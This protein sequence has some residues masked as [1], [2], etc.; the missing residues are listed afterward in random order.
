MKSGYYRI[1][2]A[3]TV[4]GGNKTGQTLTV[5]T[6]SLTISGQILIGSSGAA[7]AFVRAEKQGGGFSGTQ[8]DANG[9]YILPVDAGTWKIL[10]VAEGYAEAAYAS[11]PI[12]VST[13]VSGKNI[14]LTTT[15]SLD[16][17]KSKPITPS[18]GGTL[19][20]TTAGVKLTIPAN[21]LGSG[22]SAGNIQAKETN[23]VRKTSSATPIGDKAQEIKATDSDGNPI[24]TLND[25]INVEMSYSTA[26]LATTRSSG[27]SSINTKTEV[28]KLQMAYWDET[29]QNWVTLPT[30]ITYYKSDGT[31]LDGSDTAHTPL[32]NLSNVATTTMSAPTTHLSLYAPISSTGENPPSTPSGLTATAASVSQINLS[33]T[34]VSGATSYDIYQSTT[35]DGTYTRLGSEPTVSSGSTVS[36]SDTGLSAGTAYYYKI[37][38]LNANGESVAS[39]AVSATTN[40]APA[41]SPGSSGIPL[42]QLQNQQTQ[43]QQA[44]TTTEAIKEIITET[45]QTIKE[46]TETAKQ[47]AQEFAQ[48]IV[49]ITLEAA[50]VIKA[51]VDNILNLMGVKRNV[52]SEQAVINKYLRPLV[53][54]M[55]TVTADA[56]HALTNF[57]SYGTPTTKILG[58]GE[59]AGVINSY[60]SAFG[61]LPKTEAEW[62]DVIK[63]G[64]GRWPSEINKQSE[65]NAS[66]AFE[67]IYKRKADRKNP[68]D[69]AAITVIAYG[70]R[71]AK[72]NTDSEKAAIKS[73]KAIYGY[74]PKTAV[75]WDIVRAIAYSGAKR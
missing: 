71:P 49:D 4:N 73:F 15:V 33:W 16:P 69:D 24:N 70:L 48:K 39:S 10:A 35:S 31:I 59:R 32:D 6:A 27:D 25:S 58:A 42:N 28:D 14:T 46:V 72:R 60:K 18:S 17:I 12:T 34:V 53:A 29:T 40:S 68:N 44:T 7:N 26:E 67:K 19:E 54:G 43:Q 65:I 63:I 21:A 61:K 55:G 62:N 22:S 11:N 56:Q 13:S 57:I 64:N 37:T 8:A 66:A 1:P 47:T 38:A 51:Q 52:N 41:S 23:N 30:T 20:D 74:E 75:A 2:T 45:K 5:S 3:L 50:E 36:Y 9:N